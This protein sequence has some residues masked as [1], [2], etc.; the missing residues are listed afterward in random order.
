MIL[1]LFIALLLAN[2]AVRQLRLP[3][4]VELW[5]AF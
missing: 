2:L 3:L 4:I 1:F 5:G